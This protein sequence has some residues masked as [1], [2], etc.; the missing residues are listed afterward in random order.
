MS[1]YRRIDYIF[2]SRDVPTGPNFYRS[3]L[4]QISRKGFHRR[5][6]DEERT[7]VGEEE[8]WPEYGTD[9]KGNNSKIGVV[10]P[11]FPPGGIR[12]GVGVGRVVFQ[13][14]K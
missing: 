12:G 1:V 6:D 3:L 11:V 4:P 10:Q 14:K 5:I 8:P 13:G 7:V 2:P 9:D